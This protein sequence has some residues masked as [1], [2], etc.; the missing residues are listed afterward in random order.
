MIETFKQFTFEAAHRL[1]PYSTLHGHSFAVEI[2]LKGEPHP[3]FGWPA[4]LT[5][6]DAQIAAVRG[7]L[8]E[9]CLN[10]VEGLEVPS[11]ENI[12]RWI[13][14]RLKVELPCIDR[15]TVRRGVD[16]HAEGCTF[17]ER[18]RRPRHPG[19]AAA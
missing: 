6:I 14:C 13:W 15:V 3:V 7:A 1:P 12:A 4:S 5:D 16:G 17:R 2:V 19:T 8:D 18:R 9:R 10:E 11:L